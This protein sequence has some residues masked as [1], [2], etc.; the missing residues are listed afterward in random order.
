[1]TQSSRRPPQDVSR[2]YATSDA[3]ETRSTELWTKLGPN[4]GIPSRS[5]RGVIP[6]RDLEAGMSSSMEGS[7]WEVQRMRDKGDGVHDPLPF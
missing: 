2:R 6:G 5:S 4:G 7:R 3:A 1:M